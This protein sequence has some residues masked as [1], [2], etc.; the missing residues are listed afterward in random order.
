VSSPARSAAVREDLNDLSV[1]LGRPE[2]FA[3]PTA[4]TLHRVPE[5]GS[6]PGLARLALAMAAPDMVLA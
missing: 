2:G 1:A 5:G 4:A 6:Q 3:P